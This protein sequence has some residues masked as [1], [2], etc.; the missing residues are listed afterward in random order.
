MLMNSKTFGSILIVAGTSV[1]ASMLALPMIS[2]SIGEL[3]SLLLLVSIWLLVYYASLVV[4]KVNLFYKGAFSIAGLCKKSFGFKISLIA[5]LSIIILFYS[6][7][8]AYISG[9]VEV[10]KLKTIAETSCLLNKGIL[11]YVVVGVLIFFI[12]FNFKILDV[13]NR[14][15]FV[16]KICFF[17]TILYF[18]SIKLELNNLKNFNE[19]LIQD[20]NLL[21][22]IPLFFTSFGF[23]GSI[24]FIIKYLDN[25]EQDIKKAFLYGSLLSL[26]IYCFWIFFT[27]AVL[28]RCGINSFDTVNNSDD[29]LHTFIRMLVERSGQN[30]L[31]IIVSVFSWLAIITS[32]LG[33]GVG[34]YDYI[35]E[36]FKF[37]KKFFK[38][39]LNVI[40][41]TFC[42]PLLIAIF[43]ENIFINALAFAA[44]SLSMLAIIF[45][46]LIALKLGQ[47]NKVLIIVSLIL[48]IFI[49]VFEFINFLR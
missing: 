14:V 21:K 10:S 17:I 27:L 18:L 15:I 9:I 8:A 29:K 30:K 25:N 36:K 45:P 13:S 5:D 22:A 42:P 1:G 19:Y 47:N 6:L 39:Q 43:G 3:N 4:L 7:L 46:A 2:S 31:H 20:N 26:T 32:F 33:A 11:G 38:D 12:I 41:I 28:P 37:K 35:M 16:I 23:H 40:L 48:G 24:P 34:L 44:I 49:I